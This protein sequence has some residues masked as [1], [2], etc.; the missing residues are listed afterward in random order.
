MSVDTLPPPPSHEYLEENIAPQMLAIVGT[1]VAI[2][3]ICVFLRIY[4]R[5]CM[6]KNFGIDGEYLLSI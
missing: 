4:V 2:A 3:V 5:A 6:L 1:S